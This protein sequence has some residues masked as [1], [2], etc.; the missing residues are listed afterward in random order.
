MFVMTACVAFT[1][2]EIFSISPG[3]L[4]PIST[5]AA[6]FSFFRVQT[7]IGT[8]TWLFEFPCVFITFSFAESATSEDDE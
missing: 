6:W 5:T 1:T 2:A 3:M 4:T 7:V 8:P